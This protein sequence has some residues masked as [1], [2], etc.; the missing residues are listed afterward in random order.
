MT[1]RG[2]KYSC[3]DFDAAIQHIEA[4]RNINGE[5]R[6]DNEDLTKTISVLEGKI[7]DLN[8]TIA[9][10]QKELDDAWKQIKALE[11]EAA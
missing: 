10:L 4:A 1:Y 5:L 7:D 3:P 6:D 11:R 9:D 2:P 8:D